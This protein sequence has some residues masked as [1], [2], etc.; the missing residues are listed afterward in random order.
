MTLLL[1]NDTIV[2]VRPV[3]VEAAS[4]TAV[5]ELARVIAVN[6]DRI[7]MGESLDEALAQI[8]DDADGVDVEATTEDEAESAN[9]DTDGDDET[10]GNAGGDAPDSTYDPTGKSVVEL[11]SDADTLLADA[12]SAEASGFEIEA[13]A[14]RAQ[15]RAALEAAQELLGGS[16]TGPPAPTSQADET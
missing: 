10:D 5:P 15:A 4:R 2:Y 11:I 7:A 13:E 9:D 3:Y 6:D 16:S 1:V 8:A 12:E 14:Y